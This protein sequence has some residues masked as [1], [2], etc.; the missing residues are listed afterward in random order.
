MVFFGE[1]FY[2]FNKGHVEL[3]RTMADRFSNGDFNFI[4]IGVKSLYSRSVKCEINDE[5]PP[6]FQRRDLTFNLRLDALGEETIRYQLKPVNRGVYN[7]G[8]VNAFISVLTHLVQR[9]IGNRESK[10]V[11]VFPSFLQLRKYELAL[12]SFNQSDSGIKKIRKLGHSS[13]FDQIKSYVPGDDPRHINWK[14]SARTSHLMTNHFIDEKS[15]AI[16]HVIDTGRLMKFPFDGMTL[17]DYAINTSLMLSHIAILKEDKAGLVTFD[18]NIRTFVQAEKSKKQMHNIMDALYAQKEEFGEANFE[19]LA[20]SLYSKLNKRCLLF[21]Y[22][23]FESY[24]SFERKLRY[25]RILSKKHLLVIILFQNTGLEQLINIQPTDLLGVYDQIIAEQSKSEKYR[26]KLMLA[27]YGIHCI[28]TTPSE[29]SI[30]GL[31]KYLELKAS[32]KM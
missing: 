15:Q 8:Q 3:T 6:Q 31:N 32:G 29:L 19:M 10:D 4:T 5:I 17:L 1:I 12:F 27:R 22:T 26:I 11:T 16:Y 24:T 18:K 7:F 25:F 2:L 21:V 23:N 30:N 14:S 28:L 20:T 13:E 9:R